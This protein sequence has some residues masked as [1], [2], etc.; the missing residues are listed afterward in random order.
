M[1]LRQ[2]ALQLLPHRLARVVRFGWTMLL[3]AGC[4]YTLRPMY[5]AEVRTVHVPMAHS[6]DFRRDLEFRLTESIIK[7][8]EEKTPY[9]VVDR[10]RADTV[11][12]ARILGLGKRVRNETPTDEPRELELNLIVEVSWHDQRNGLLLRGPEEITLPSTFQRVARTADMVPEIGETF[13]TASQQAIDD[14]AEQVVAMM[15]EPW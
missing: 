8:I 13:A 6:N 4:G 11:L 9:K 12:E 2:R 7:E 5:P 10:D 1:P 3:L 14:L 15:E